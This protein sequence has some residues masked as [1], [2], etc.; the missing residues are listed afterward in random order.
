MHRSVT[1]P[2]EYIVTMFEG[3]GA[4]ALLLSGHGQTGSS[5][6]LAVLAQTRLKRPQ[7]K[8][9]H[10]AIV[11]IAITPYTL[12]NILFYTRYHSGQVTLRTVKVLTP[13]R[14]CVFHVSGDLSFSWSV[15]SRLHRCR[16]YRNV[17]SSSS[18]T[19]VAELCGRYVSFLCLSTDL[20]P[21]SV[22]PIE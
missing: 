12:Q 6:A 3:K 2:V 11:N 19:E 13:T 14:P 20:I 7:G 22:L 1:A 18:S 8:L 15:S 10:L 16:R 5:L 9:Q 4:A 17:Y 21:Q